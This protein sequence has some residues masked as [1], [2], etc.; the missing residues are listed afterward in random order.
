M[1]IAKKEQFEQQTDFTMHNQKPQTIK[2]Q[3]EYLISALPNIGPIGAK[4]LL[5][6]FKSIK[7]I[8]NASEKDLQQAELIGPKKSKQ[9]FDLF[10]VEWKE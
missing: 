1:S 7:N 9:L 4:P 5:K 2:D 6:E 10:N 8:I 3:Q